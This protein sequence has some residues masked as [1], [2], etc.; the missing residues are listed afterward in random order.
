MSEALG[1]LAPFDDEGNLRVVVETPRGATVKID[2]DAAHAVF[3]VG[4]ALPLG[5]AYPYDWGFVPGTRADDGDPLDAMVLHE[6]S[7]YPG[8]VL[9]CRVLGM[10]ALTQRGSGRNRE[11]NHRI[12]ALPTFNERLGDVRDHT[13]LPARM[14]AE[15]EQFFATATFFTGKDVKLEGWRS[16]KVAEAFI[17]ASRR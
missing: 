3:T 5:V 17:R 15:I 14:R 9:S 7:T 4:R 11:R 13:R 16:G 8:V 12:I 10:V 2:F 6:A 1:R